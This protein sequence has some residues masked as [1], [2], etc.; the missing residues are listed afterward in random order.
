VTDADTKGNWSIFFFHPRE[1]KGET[2]I[3]STGARWCK[4]GVPG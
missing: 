4:T 3:L 1:P 2:V